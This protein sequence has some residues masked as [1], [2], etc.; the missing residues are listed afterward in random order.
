MDIMNYQARSTTQEEP[1]R[2]TSPTDDRWYSTY[3]PIIEQ[4]Q[5]EI[6]DHIQRY[7]EDPSGSL[8]CCQFLCDTYLKVS[9]DY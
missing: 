4:D 2:S 8:F 3:V 5:V 9:R 6:Q 7:W 1:L